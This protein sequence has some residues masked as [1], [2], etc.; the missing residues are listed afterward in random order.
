MAYVDSEYG[1]GLAAEYV[2]IGNVQ[3]NVLPSDWYGE[4]CFLPL[5]QNLVAAFRL[6]SAKPS[7]L[8]VDSF[9]PP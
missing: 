2:E 7:R 1:A 3:A 9:P 8:R 4:T 6:G 5:L